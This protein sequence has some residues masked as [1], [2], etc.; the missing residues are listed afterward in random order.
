M[1]ESAPLGEPAPLA[2]AALSGSLFGPSGAGGLPPDT[3][4]DEPLTQIGATSARGLGKPEESCPV[5]LIVIGGSRAPSPTDSER[6][7]ACATIDA[8]LGPVPTRPDRTKTPATRL[9]GAV[10]E[11]TL[12]SDTEAEVDRS[13]DGST[14]VPTEEQSAPLTPTAPLDETV[15]M[16]EGEGAK[17][18]TAQEAELL[19]SLFP[20]LAGMEEPVQ[21][22]ITPERGTPQGARARDPSPV[23]VGESPLSVR[24]DHSASLFCI[25]RVPSTAGPVPTT[26]GDPRF[27]G[28]ESTLLPPRRP[29]PT[30][31]QQLFHLPDDDELQPIRSRK[32]RRSTGPPRTAPSPDYVDPEERMDAAQGHWSESGSDSPE[33]LCTKG[34][35]PKKR[36]KRAKTSR[37]GQV[38][39]TRSMPLRFEP[40]PAPAEYLPARWF[41]DELRPPSPPPSVHS[42]TYPHLPGENPRSVLE[43]SSFPTQFEPEPYSEL[44]QGRDE[45][46]WAQGQ[47][48]RPVSPGPRRYRRVP[49]RSGGIPMGTVDPSAVPSTSRAAS[50]PP[51]P[52]QPRG[53]RDASLRMHVHEGP[54]SVGPW[55]QVYQEGDHTQRRGEQQQQQQRTFPQKKGK[56]GGHR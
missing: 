43:R 47:A 50:V 27:R 33:Y 46:R 15:P 37:K 31:Y 41:L 21:A 40:A 10:E 14:I 19:A 39:V 29:R 44:L 42:D 32:G 11:I 53:L 55:E 49:G 36:K 9:I 4:K 24:D 38:D 52:F 3:K 18:T 20:Q 30:H 25:D 34:A 28:H 22:Q 16:E 26:A 13:S 56:G 6:A 1:D 2:D 54:T 48:R 5:Q 45:Y 17:E 8:H 12:S 23:T 35:K 51:V 7:M